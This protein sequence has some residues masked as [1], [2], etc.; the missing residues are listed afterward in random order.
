[1]QA[2]GIEGES[3]HSYNTHLNSPLIANNLESSLLI[4]LG[5]MLKD[6]IESRGMTQKKSLI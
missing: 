4:Y 3:V 6:E 2:H 1:M 5:K